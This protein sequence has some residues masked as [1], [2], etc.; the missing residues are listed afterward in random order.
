ME[1]VFIFSLIR[2][3]MT[4]VLLACSGAYWFIDLRGTGRSRVIYRGAAAKGVW[5]CVLVGVNS[6]KEQQETRLGNREQ[7]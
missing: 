2:G 4:T 1:N 6:D 3:E 7:G 5:V